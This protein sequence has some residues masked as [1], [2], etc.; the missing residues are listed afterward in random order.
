[1]A[2]TAGGR[3][4]AVGH[5]GLRTY[6]D[7]GTH[8]SRPVLGKEGEIYRAVCFGNGRWAAVGTYGGWNILATTTDGATWKTLAQNLPYGIY[9]RSIGFARGMFLGLGGDPGAVGDSHP[10]RTQ[11]ADGMTWRK[12]EDIPGKN[13]LRRF[14]F[15]KGL[16]VGVGDRGRR[17]ASSDGRTWKDSPNTRALDTLIDVAFGNGVFVGV[18]LHGLRMTTVDGLTWTDRQLGEEGEH[19]NTILWAGGRFVAVGLGATYFSSD[20]RR[21][22]RRK[23]SNAPL[24]FTYGKGAFVGSNWKGRLLRS[25]DAVEWKQVFKCEYHVEAVAFGDPAAK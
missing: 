20:G 16:F 5:R 2:G 12:R 7:D 1:M 3:F 19:I 4:V 15:G 25:A 14:A 24:A 22:E 9:I 13:I 23:N 17:S 11:S 10:F 8:W 18:G 21:W 6:S